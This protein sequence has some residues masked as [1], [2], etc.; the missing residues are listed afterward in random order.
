MRFL[1]WNLVLVSVLA[2]AANASTRPDHLRAEN[3]IDPLGID[4]PAPR[5]S[6]TLNGGVLQRAYQ[7]RAAT[8]TA[9]LNQEIADL[10]D[11]GKVESSSATGVA[12]GGPTLHSRNPVVWQVRVW[13]DQSSE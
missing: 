11:S 1:L 3:R 7:V 13:T 5:L 4:V 8:S 9:L 2:A 6:W 10:W 12:Y